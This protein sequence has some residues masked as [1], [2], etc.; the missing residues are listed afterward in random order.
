[1]CPHRHGDLSC[2]ID[3]WLGLQA[4]QLLLV[5]LENVSLNS[6]IKTVLCSVCKCS[7]TRELL[8]YRIYVTLTACIIYLFSFLLSFSLCFLICPSIPDWA[9]QFLFFTPIPI[10]SASLSSPSLSPAFTP[11]LPPLH[12]CLLFYLALQCYSQFRKD[13]LI[14]T[15]TGVK[16]CFKCERC[17]IHTTQKTCLPMP[18]WVMWFRRKIYNLYWQRKI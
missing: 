17:C 5:H 12:P 1:M 4:W 14:Q 8:V 15:S 6:C 2:S 7:K 18:E 10:W 3:H 11:S 9:V 16:M 13:F